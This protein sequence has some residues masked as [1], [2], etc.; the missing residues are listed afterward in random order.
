MVGY[1]FIGAGCGL[2]FLAVALIIRYFKRRS[3]PEKKE[4]KKTHEK[5]DVLESLLE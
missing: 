5:E 4:Q 2:A 1:V 3:N